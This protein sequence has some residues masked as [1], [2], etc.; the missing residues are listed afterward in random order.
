MMSFVTIR[1]TLGL[2][3]ALVLLFAPAQAQQA[4]T[5]GNARVQIIH[6][7]ADPAANLVD[8]EIADGGTTVSTFDDVAFRSATAFFDLAPGTYDVTVTDES[9]PGI[10]IIDQSVTVAD[11]GAY[12]LIANGVGDPGQFQANPNGEDISATLLVNEMARETADEPEEIRFNIVHG[13]TD[14]PRFDLFANESQLAN[15]LTYGVVTAYAGVPAGEY[16][17]Q[18]TNTAGTIAF[19][20]FLADFSGLGGQAFSLAVSGFLTPGNE[21]DTNGTPPSFGLLA[22]LPDGTTFL[23]PALL[24]ADNIVE[25]RNAPLGTIVTVEGTVTRA[26]GDFTRIQDETGGLTIRQTSGPFMEDVNDG[27]ITPGTIL[28]VTGATSEFANLLQI[29]G[30]VETE[31]DYEILGTEALPDPQLVTLAELSTNGE[32]YESELV[33]LVDL[34]IEPDG[35]TDFQQATTYDISDATLSDGS[36]TLRVSNADD[37]ELDGTPIPLAPFD[38]TGVVGQFDFDDPTVGYQILPI[39]ETDI[40]TGDGMLTMLQIIHN[41]PD[42][43]FTEVDIYVNGGLL[44]DDFAFRTATAFFDVAAGVELEIAVAPGTSGSAEDAVFTETYTLNPKMNY[45]LIATGVG[46]GSF[47]VNPDGNDIAFTLLVNPDAFLESDTDDTNSDLNFVHGATDA[48]AVDVRTGVTQDIIL[49]DDVAYGALAGYQPFSPEPQTL[50]V[51][52][53]DGV[54]SVAMFSVDLTGRIDEAG[55]ILASGFLTPDNEDAT[56]G[57]PPSFGLLV[58]FADGS[59][60]FVEPMSVSNEDGTALPT[61]FTLRGTYPNPLATSTTVRYDL[62]T[63]AEVGLEVYDVLGRRVLTLEPQLVT[64][65]ANRTLT[66]DAALPSGTYLYRVTAE[67]A[68]EM[69]TETGRMTIVR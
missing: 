11:G 14:T 64:A 27:T 20:S 21:D 5:G 50:E 44:E 48:P 4:T 68:T 51:T 55:T 25:A 22:V 16:A 8:I 40:E 38:Y 9:D 23:L 52:T 12:Q 17:V 34:S 30:G 58:V 59:E 33:Q 56:N 57:T 61:T 31:D 24:D 36:V 1:H 53:A 60:T 42:P 65:G 54:T 49:F 43:A 63:D 35:D 18:V 15:D 19:A 41:A 37:T 45:Q 69:L 7:A 66:V 2:C 28:R 3:T 32:A 6:N 62:P 67:T 10:V 29:N 26:M 13:A 39:Q 46:E 47:E